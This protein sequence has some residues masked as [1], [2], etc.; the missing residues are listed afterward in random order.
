MI[1]LPAPFCLAHNFINF[2]F[3]RCLVMRMCVRVLFVSVVR[4]FCT[5]YIITGDSISAIVTNK[6]YYPTTFI[7]LFTYA[8]GH[9]RYDVESVEH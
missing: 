3:V 4:E 2:F 8:R 9:S 7:I 5:Y 1:N 6:Y